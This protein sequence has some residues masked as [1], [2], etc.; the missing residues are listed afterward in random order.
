MERVLSWV[1]YPRQPKSPHL[2]LQSIPVCL[3]Q[4]GKSGFEGQEGAGLV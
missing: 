3:C 1:L 2:W 4:E